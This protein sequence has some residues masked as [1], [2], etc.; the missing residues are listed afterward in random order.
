MK[1]DW[2]NAFEYELTAKGAKLTSP[3]LDGQ[4]GTEDDLVYLSGRFVEQSTAPE[5]AGAAQ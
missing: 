1:D 2:G 5:G 3:G 4:L